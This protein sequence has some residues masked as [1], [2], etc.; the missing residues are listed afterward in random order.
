[1]SSNPSQVLEATEGFVCNIEGEQFIVNLGLTR[2]AASHPLAV[3]YP[4]R[5]RPVEDSAT[6]LAYDGAAT[7]TDEPGEPAR[8]RVRAVAKAPVTPSPASD[9]TKT[10]SKES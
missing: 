8:Q 5:F 2:V 4:E 9:G 3:H 6:Y 1:M 10:A 7:A